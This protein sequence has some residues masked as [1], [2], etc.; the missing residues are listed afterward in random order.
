[1]RAAIKGKLAL[2][3]EECQPGRDS[4]SLKWGRFAASVG[5]RN[6]VRTRCRG[7]AWAPVAFARATPVH[8]HSAGHPWPAGDGWAGPHTDTSLRH[9][10]ERGRTPI[11]LHHDRRGQ[12]RVTKS[13]LIAPISLHVA[14]PSGRSVTKSGL[15]S[16]PPP[17]RKPNTRQT[18][19]QGPGRRPEAEAPADR[20]SAD[21]DIDVRTGPPG[22]AGPQSPAPQAAPISEAGAAPAQPGWWVV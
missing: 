19:P 18:N 9:K 5:P 22:W 6:P 16:T 11:S 1:M 17:P 20:R 2:S 8:A 7:S 14:L 10:H 13:A 15:P 12:Q 4:A 21:G 3:C